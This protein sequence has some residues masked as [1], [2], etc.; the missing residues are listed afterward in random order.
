MKSRMN[1]FAAILLCLCSLPVLAAEQTITVST[2]GEAE[3]K[4]DRIVLTGEIS[5]SNEKLKDAVTAFT[6]TRRRAL[7]GLKE[8][9]VENMTVTT[10]K[11]SMSLA[12]APQANPFG[13]GAPAEPV[14]PGSLVISQSVTLTVTGIDALEQE[15]LVDLVVKLLAGVKDVGL[16]T[17]ATPDAEGM[18][19]MQMMGMG[20]GG[21]SG[22]SFTIG[23]P[24]NATKAATKDAVAKARADAA[25]LA[26]LAGGKL[27][28]VVRISDGPAAE[29][30]GSTMNPYAMIFGAMMNAAADPYAG[31]TLD[32]ITVKR[33]LTV[34]FE[35][36]HD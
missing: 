25:Y 21:G 16:K 1:L 33:P 27:G 26:E 36:I 17:G 35:L 29:E 19:M 2:V 3:L 18:M 14:A 13:G 7:A 15:A 9:D 20:G 10:S 32:A 22:A 5:E 28:K 12:G 6:D 24:V 34:T 30:Q 23:D 8:L 4:P 11:L 31:E